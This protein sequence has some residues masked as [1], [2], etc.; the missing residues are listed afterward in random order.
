MQR[1]PAS[2]M[3][4]T[5]PDPSAAPLAS[6][7]E[8]LLPHQAAW[9]LAGGLLL[10]SGGE[11]L[12]VGRREIGEVEHPDP[13]LGGPLQHRHLVGTEPPLQAE[14]PRVVGRDGRDAQ[15]QGRVVLRSPSLARTTPARAGRASQRGS[16]ADKGLRPPEQPLPSL[17]RH[18]RW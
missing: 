2:S 18:H 14:G 10:S 12:L 5:A 8:P 16:L 15:G 13:H 6:G 9:V 3:T 4:A 11:A 1:F 17:R 7:T